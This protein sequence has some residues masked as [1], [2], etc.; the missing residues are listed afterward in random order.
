MFLLNCF[1]SL[2]FF[3]AFLFATLAFITDLTIG[4]AAVKDLDGAVGVVAERA[5]GGGGGDG[6]TTSLFFSG[7]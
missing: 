6:V 3:S 5:G 7:F 1:G 4:P 2:A